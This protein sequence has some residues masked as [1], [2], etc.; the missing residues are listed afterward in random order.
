MA[1]TKATS[2]TDAWQAVA[3]D[4]V[5][6]GGA[7]NLDDAYGA[8]LHIDCAISNN[9]AHTGTKISVQLNSDSSDADDN[10]HTFREF[11]T[12]SG[13]ANT[14]TT[15]EALDVAEADIDLTASPA[16]GYT[17][18]E[19]RWIFLL[20]GTVANSEIC[21]LESENDASTITVT[22]GVT[23]AH[24]SGITVSNIVDSYV[25]ELPFAADKARVVYDNTYDSDGA[26]VHVRCRLSKVTAL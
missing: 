16:T 19:I 14:T 22:D 6:E 8:I 3:Q 26:Q 18:D 1:I 13:T 20:D 9:T 17:A 10:W 21:L 11:I 23:H 5:A 15:A 12:S 4:T 25:I 7:S 2:E 24:S